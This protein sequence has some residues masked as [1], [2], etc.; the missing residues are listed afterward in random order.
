M[1]LAHL[2]KYRYNIWFV[3]A[4]IINTFASYIAPLTPCKFI[5][6]ERQEKRIHAAQLRASVSL[7]KKTTPYYIPVE[8]YERLWNIPTKRG[9]SGYVIS[10]VCTTNRVSPLWFIVSRIEMDQWY[11]TVRQSS[12]QSNRYHGR[13]KSRT[14]TCTFLLPPSKCWL[15]LILSYVSPASPCALSQLRAKFWYYLNEKELHNHCLATHDLR[16]A[17]YHSRYQ[18]ISVFKTGLQ[19]NTISRLI[20]QLNKYNK[21]IN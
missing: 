18:L 7:N 12:S 10:S 14:A 16:Y 21:S 19:R 15:A 17:F 9:Y 8:M 20:D 11:S 1:S 3:Y 4:I 5:L 6:K 13:L 2:K